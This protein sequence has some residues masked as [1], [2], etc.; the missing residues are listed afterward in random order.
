MP[1]TI[2]NRLRQMQVFNLLHDAYC[3][4]RGCSCSEITVVVTDENP[5]TGERAPRR[6]PKKVPAALTLL[7]REVRAGLPASVLQVPD[8]R[9][10]IGARSPARRGA[11][12]ETRRRRRLPR[13]ARAL[14]AAA[15]RS[16]PWARSFSPPRSSSSRRNLASGTC[17]RC[18]RPWSARS[19]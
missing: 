19:A 11:D 12:A 10:A 1:V 7:A 13:R 16:R 8:V 17:P 15:G 4:G 18:P 3:R 14:L 6:V 5:R 2:E 9:A